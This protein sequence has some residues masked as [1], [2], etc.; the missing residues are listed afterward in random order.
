MAKKLTA[1]VLQGAQY[2]EKM[3][4][5]W[6]G[7]IYE[8]EIR[9]LMNNEASEIEALL[10]EGV[11]VKGKPGIK[12]RMERVV[13]FDTKKN[14]YGRYKADIKA[15]AYGT[16]DESLTEEV[17]EREFPR[18]L[19]K[20]IAERIK[21]ISGIGNDEEVEEFNEGVDNPYD[22]SGEQ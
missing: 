16:T 14:T 17:I 19:V 1:G 20:E 21:K 9:P 15:V 3:N 8:I 22:K 4:V 2:R 12:G 7:E 11:S 13:D 10:Q 18:K 6:L 5:E